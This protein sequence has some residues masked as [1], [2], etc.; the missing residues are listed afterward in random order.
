MAEHQKASQKNK[1]DAEQK[2]RLK[3]KEPQTSFDHF[4]A[5][6]QGTVAI[7]E[8]PF[9]PRMDE[10]AELLA[11]PHSDEQRASLVLQL[12]QTYGNRY[13]QRLIE[14]MRGQ[15]KLTVNDPND[16]Y[17]QEADSVAHAVSNHAPTQIQ[18][19]EEEEEES[20]EEKE[21]E[22]E[23]QA[24]LFLQR[25]DI[26]EEEEK[27]QTKHADFIQ[28]QV[29]DLV[30][31]VDP[32]IEGKI[33]AA[34][35]RGEPL[36]DNTREPME[37]AFGTDFSGVR[38]HNDANAD[39]LSQSLQARAFTTGQDIFFRSG[40]YNPASSAGQQ[41]LAHELTHTIQQGGAEKTSPVQQED[42]PAKI[43]GKIQPKATIQRDT[44]KELV[45]Y[46]EQKIKEV[47][48]I[49]EPTKTEKLPPEAESKGP[50]E[51]ESKG[52]TVPVRW[53]KLWWEG[54]K[55]RRKYSKSYM[56]TKKELMER[57]G[58]PGWWAKMTLPFGLKKKSP[59]VQ[60]LDKLEKYHQHVR[61]YH[62]KMEPAPELFQQQVEEVR[63]VWNLLQGWN[64][65]K[66]KNEAMKGAIDELERQVQQEK[67]DRLEKIRPWVTAKTLTEAREEVTEGEEKKEGKR[68]GGHVLEKVDPDHRDFQV[69]QM[70]YPKWQD[71]I[72]KQTTRLEF[73][74]WVT[75]Q[76]K[77]RSEMLLEV[78]HKRY[79]MPSCTWGIREKNYGKWK[80]KFLKEKEKTPDKLIDRTWYLEEKKA[81]E[82]AK[83]PEQIPPRENFELTFKGTEVWRVGKRIGGDYMFVMSPGGKFYAFQE[84]SE[85]QAYF[86]HS[87]FLAGGA[88]GAAGVIKPGAEITINPESGHYTPGLQQMVNAVR[89]LI[90][91]HVPP[92]QIK[93]LYYYGCPEEEKVSAGDLLEGLGALKQPG[94][95]DKI[96]RYLTAEAKIGEHEAIE[97][98]VEWLKDRVEK[99][100]QAAES[101]Y[102]RK[103]RLEK[104]GEEEQAAEKEYD[105]RKDF[106]D[107]TIFMLT[108]MKGDLALETGELEELKKLEFYDFQRWLENKRNELQ[109]QLPSKK[110]V[111]KAGKESRKAKGKLAKPLGADWEQN[112]FL[113][114]MIDPSIWNDTWR[115]A[116]Q[117]VIL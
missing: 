21:E 51:V 7:T 56:M 71:E 34:R 4:H 96:S 83:L 104:E 24:Q 97:K 87:S 116:I 36:D 15:A 77:D 58:E 80:E 60:I 90:N 74:K 53:Y 35:G 82:Q 89:G 111:K 2:H 47:K 113:T 26:P 27:L 55:E 100:N 102:K 103:D 20:E 66:I 115:Q 88:A 64:W 65:R 30:P 93:V 38:V 72:D 23:I 32:E 45:E 59:H 70:L 106:Q 107:R 40:E 67:T 57:G 105:D 6:E 8:T 44:V 91:E 33:S 114:N 14:S 43:N 63:E 9:W 46:H 3:Q 39:A 25:Q 117:Q 94:V 5:W 48:G 1:E 85:T 52:P 18:R 109:E 98:L 16:I 54:E 69:L 112:E 31:E 37:Q 101:D 49:R 68:K 29:T 22:E 17:E 108:T 78:M 73:F 62:A 42:E 76:E 99:G 28:R 10:H 79:Q 92:E 110:E 12:Q 19:Q 13:V 81:E 50:P 86:H 61:Q 41:L 75:Q 11:M 84:K 95:M